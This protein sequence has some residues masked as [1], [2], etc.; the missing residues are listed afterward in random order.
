[1]SR[2]SLP[3]RK[4]P[5]PQAGLLSRRGDVYSNWNGV[6]VFTPKDFIAPKDIGEL[7]EVIKRSARL[8]IVGS[9]HSMNAAIAAGPDA[10]LV[11]LNNLKRI[12]KPTKEPGGGHSV[13]IEAGAT[14]GDAAAALSREGFAFPCLPQSPKITLGGMIANG[15]HGSSLREPASLAEHVMDL[16]LITSSGQLTLVPSEL[17]PLARVSLGCLGAITRVKVRVVA[18]FQLVSSSETLSADAA[19]ETQNLIDDLNAHNFQLSYTYDPVTHTVTRRTLDRV[20]PSQLNRFADYP[21]KTQYDQVSFECIKSCALICIARLPNSLFGLRDTAKRYTC[22][23][24]L[25]IE[26]RIGESRFMFQTNLNHP[27]HDMAYA[28][29]I[30]RCREILEKIAQEFRRVGYQPDLPLGMRFLKGTDK[31]ALA[32]N[33]SQDVAVIE[34]ASLIEFHDNAEAFRLFEHV[35]H[36]AG[37]RPHWAKEFSFNPKGAYPEDVWFAFSD[38]SARWGSKFANEWSLR[39]SPAGDAIRIND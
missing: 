5:N 26:R 30:G 7:Q 36:G 9:C 25:P 22:A 17:L 11:Q 24:A 19:L 14:L 12:E 39:F 4:R 33:S 16:E 20:E 28:V 32:M 13:W 31:V 27:A 37:G 10:I 18:N 21:R 35:L 29:P 3:S 2:D 38:L 1:M 34:W 15:V 6:V 8:R 23:G